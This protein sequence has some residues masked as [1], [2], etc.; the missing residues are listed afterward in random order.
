MAKTEFKVGQLVRSVLT[1][2]IGRVVEVDP[3]YFGARQAFKVFGAERGQAIGP[4]SENG[5]GP[6]KHGIRDRVKVQWYTNYEATN[7]TIE[8]MDGKDIIA[9]EDENEV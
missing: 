5:I 9:L 1:N 8:S 4:G 3:D 2:Y 7:T 6:T